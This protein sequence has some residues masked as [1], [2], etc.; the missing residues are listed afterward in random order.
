VRGI[1]GPVILVGNS[2]GFLDGM[3]VAAALGRPVRVVRLRRGFGQSADRMYREIEKS[4]GAANR[5]HT[6]CV[7]PQGRPA[8][9]TGVSF[10]P[11]LF[12]I[13]SETKL[14][15]VPFALY[16]RSLSTSIQFAQAVVPVP[17]TQEFL[18][19]EIHDQVEFLLESLAR[20]SRRRRERAFQETLLALMILKSDSYGSRTATCL[21]DGER[22]N[23]LSYLELSRRARHLSDYLIHWG[24]RRGDRVSILSESRP[25]WGVAFFSIIRAGGVCVPLDTKLT[26][27]EMVSILSDAQPRVL[28]VS[29]E[30]L[31]KGRALK[32]LIPTIENV[33]V[34]SEE[35][36]EGESAYGQLRAAVPT[37]GRK[38]DPE[39]LALIIY[40]SGTTGNPKGVMITFG[41]LIFQ[42]RHFNEI[43]NLT[44]RDMFLSILPLNHLFEL[45]GGFIGVLHAGG[46]ICYSLNLNPQ[47][48]AK[49][50][51]EKKV[52]GMVTVPL[53]LKMLKMSI[54]KEIR[55]LSPPRR[56]AFEF[57]YR[58]SKWVPW[59]PAR[60]FLFCGIHAQFG[61]RLKGFISGGAPLDLEVG[62]FFYRIGIPVYQG[63][64]LTETSPVVSVNTPK[65]SRFGSVGR[66]LNG[67]S[68]EIFKSG[69]EAQGEIVTRGPHIMKGYYKRP[70]LT[71]EVIDSH[72]WFHTGDIGRI[73]K[74]GF[75]Y[76]T[77]R[78]K[79]LIV[80]GGGKK[81]HPEEV[82][83]CLTKSDLFKEV[84]VLGVRTKYTEEVTAV[85]VPL[86][87]VTAQYSQDAQVLGQIV[88]K[89]VARLARDL[90]PYKRPTAVR[91]YPSDLP[92]TATRKIKR[93]V[94]SHWILE[95]SEV[96][97]FE[98]DRD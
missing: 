74:D 61:G 36:A 23:T 25:E 30:F 9:D 7:F 43:L 54:E 15:I 79:N 59:Y 20:R 17:G 4:I 55:K 86:E 34:L 46:S 5:G 39:E 87:T 65:H 38:R 63:Y 85:V 84:C 32:T 81:V 73:D 58:I 16:R 48:I 42:V 51:K 93:S 40:T 80:L 64:G 1:Q 68:V 95:D 6:L 83:T 98:T 2:T 8:P 3:L 22:W 47:E 71:A 12:R 41:N 96:P 94:I 72:G 56:K 28:F 89:E 14:P 45:T 92:K 18:L 77:G 11:G 52:T 62:D 53:F 70:D 78:I 69:Q 50:M 29:R 44:H 91:I 26:S 67:V 97:A 33:I 88:R 31:E 13:A 21:K 10:H 90:A 24:L 75:L 82:E 27:A 57:L 76:I 66:P 37:R 49:I 35:S 19:A 60:K